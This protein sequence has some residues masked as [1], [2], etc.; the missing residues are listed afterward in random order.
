[1]IIQCPNCQARFSLPDHALGAAGRSLKCARCGHR[2]H[3]PPTT[4]TDSPPRQPPA[5]PPSSPVEAPPADWAAAEAAPPRPDVPL[6]SEDDEP[7]DLEALSAM[8]AAGQSRDEG[9]DEMTDF[10]ALGDDDDEALRNILGGDRPSPFAEKKKSRW[11]LWL[12]LTVL[13]V[14]G[15]GAAGGYFLRTTVVETWPATEA[16]YTRL[17]IPVE[18]LGAGL[19][20][21]GSRHEF[22][23][24]D[25]GKQLVVTGTI[26]NLSEVPREVPFIRL[27]MFDKQDRILQD[28]LTQPPTDSLEP[29][30]TAQYRIALD[31]PSDAASRY[32]VDWSPGPQGTG[33]D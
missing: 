22:L 3:Q 6:Q 9:D 11:W 28:V 33:E 29:G 16:V 17:G 30:A 5:P 2:W 27:M 15:G 26:V 20:F 24:L 7:T 14:G 32:E 4:E 21:Q 25:N 13:L 31:N 8:L 10:E 18:V 23:P 1:M 12:L 19:S